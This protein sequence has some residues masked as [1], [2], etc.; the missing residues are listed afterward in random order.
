M[1]VFDLK[2]DF[3]CR[4]TQK[5]SEIEKLNIVGW[6]L[7]TFWD[8]G[9]IQDLAFWSIFSAL[10]KMHRGWGGCSRGDPFALSISDPCKIWGYAMYA[11]C[12]KYSECENMQTYVKF[13]KKWKD[14]GWLV[15]RKKT[16]PLSS[17]IS[18][19][20]HGRFFMMH[21][22]SSRILQR[23]KHGVWGASCRATGELCDLVH[24]SVR[25]TCDTE[26]R[27]KRIVAWCPFTFFYRNAGVQ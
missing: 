12:A 21:K 9:N 15:A 16:T 7:D 25:G 20:E 27:T 2:N 5:K 6:I 1:L 4:K 26:R 17:R 19:I 22:S 24:A 18:R 14:V 10:V 11:K 23:K 3:F 13:A 8:C